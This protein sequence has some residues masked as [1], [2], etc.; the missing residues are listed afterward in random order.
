L[1]TESAA[2]D[3]ETARPRDYSSIPGCPLA[4]SSSGLDQVDQFSELLA[5][6]IG[7]GVTE[8]GV[9]INVL[10]VDLVVCEPVVDGGAL[11][12]GFFGVG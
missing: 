1:V 11:M 6:W 4:F 5:A 9:V 10:G 8:V 7:A 12:G 2:K 3:G